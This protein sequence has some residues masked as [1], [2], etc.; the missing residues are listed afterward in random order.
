MISFQRAVGWC[1]TV[2]SPAETRHGVGIPKFSRYTR[3]PPLQVRVGVCQQEWYHGS[4]SLS[5]LTDERLFLIKSSLLKNH[6]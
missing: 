6:R 4:V 1:K 2:A 5:S 3:L